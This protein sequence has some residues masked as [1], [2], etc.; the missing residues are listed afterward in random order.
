LFEEVPSRFQIVRAG[1]IDREPGAEQREQ[2]FLD[3]G[4]RLAVADDLVLRSNTQELLI[5]QRQLVPLHVSER[6]LVA[7]AEDFAVDVVD[8]A[9]VRVPDGEVVASRQNSLSD[10]VAHCFYR[11]A[12]PVGLPYTVARGDPCDPRSAP[13]AHSL[14]SLATQ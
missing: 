11:G 8:I 6:E 3:D 7:E 9:A 10:Y 4:N 14:R 5:N 1:D 12:S 2:V 13:V